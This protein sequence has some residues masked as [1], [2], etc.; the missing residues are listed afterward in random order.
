MRIVHCQRDF[1]TQYIGRGSALGNPFTHKPLAKTQAYVRVE[2]V[3][4]AIGCFED[5]ARGSTCWD[6]VIPPELREK[7]WE[8]IMLLKADD[9]LG[10]Y[11]APNPCHGDVIMKLWKEK[12]A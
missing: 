4:D 8:A 11:C 12:K 10:C 5:W 2:T 1:H 7:L 3:D 6:I 9:V